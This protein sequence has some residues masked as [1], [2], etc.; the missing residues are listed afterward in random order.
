MRNYTEFQVCKSQVYYIRLY[1]DWVL[2]IENFILA[3]LWESKLLSSPYA[4]RI[5]K[6]KQEES[7]E[8]KSTAV[9]DN[10]D[11]SVPDLDLQMGEDLDQTI[12]GRLKE[13]E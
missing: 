12:D 3:K 5:Y 9:L 11:V 4:F 10:S 7:Q 8:G 2:S 1:I 6:K 13:I